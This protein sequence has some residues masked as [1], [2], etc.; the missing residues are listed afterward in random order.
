MKKLMYWA[1]MLLVLPAAY[2]D[3]LPVEAFANLPAVEDPVV[4]SDGG[5]IAV[6]V[7]NEAGSYDVMVA[8][9][10]KK[11]FVTVAS[12]NGRLIALTGSIG[13]TTNVC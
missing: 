13:L 10:N 3:E 7:R 6:L 12:S 9:Y 11:E 5:R 2:A 1:A 8:P 4:S